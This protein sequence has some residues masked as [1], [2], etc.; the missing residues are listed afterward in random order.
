MRRGDAK[1]VL[2]LALEFLLGALLFLSLLVNFALLSWNA[3]PR[4][5]AESESDQTLARELVETALASLQETPDPEPPLRSLLAQLQN[6]RHVRITV[7]GQAAQEKTLSVASVRSPAAA[8]PAWF[9]RLF[10]PR[11]SVTV[12]PATIHDRNYGDIVI[13]AN[14]TGEVAEIWTEFCTIAATT[15]A[16]GIC[17]FV[18]ILIL[19][20]RA[21]AP[22]ADV[23]NAITKLARGDTDIKLV[24]RGPP[25]FVDIGAKI[26][27]LAADLAKIN[28]EK[29]PAH[30][31]DDAGAGGGTRPD[32]TR[33]A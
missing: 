8:A 27:G 10:Q 30:T 14:P 13:A 18:L 16:F 33:S 24:P 4:V 28:A 23:G 5:Q 22:I 31:P 15:L 26:N 11:P 12:V 20:G 6:L 25:E 21:I 3:G 19:V 9:V 17:L 32:R 2:A 7:T 29:S 1:S